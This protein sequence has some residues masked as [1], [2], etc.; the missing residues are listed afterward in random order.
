[1]AGESREKVVKTRVVFDCMIFLQAAGSTTGPAASCIDKAKGGVELC[2]SAEILAEIRDVLTRPRIQKKFRT[3]TPERIAEF[4]RQLELIAVLISDVP[5]AFVLTRDPKD[6]KYLNLAIAASAKLIVS[7]DNDLLD[8]MTDT[9]A[10]S[11]TF[12]TAHPEIRILDPIEFLRNFVPIP[13]TDP[14][15]SN[16]PTQTKPDEAS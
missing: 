1:V 5:D 13:L 7:R 8:L 6:S 11:K 2:L 9:D 15:L 4:L 10:D 12:R 16:P 14:T 3:L